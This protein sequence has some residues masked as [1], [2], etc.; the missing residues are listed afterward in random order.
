MKWLK[1]VIL[2]VASSAVISECKPRSALDDESSIRLPTNTR[3][4][5]YDIELNVNIHDGNRAYNGKVKISIVVD[6]ATNVITL[7]NKGLI[8]TQARITDE[9]DDEL[10]STLEFDEARDFLHV[11]VESVLVVGAKYSL[12]ISFNGAISEGTNGFY[13]MSYRDVESD[14]IK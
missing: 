8:I 7:H 6:A 5:N 3:P 12:E 13:Q 2:I 9:N 11:V 1:F 14:E 10:Q 4:E